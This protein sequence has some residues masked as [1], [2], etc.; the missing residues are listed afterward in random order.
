[1][2]VDRRRHIEGLHVDQMMPVDVETFFATLL[3]RLPRGA[4]DE[5]RPTLTAMRE[6]LRDT[7]VDLGATTA[8]TLDPADVDAT[9]GVI[10]ERLGQLKRREWRGKRDGERLIDRLRATVGELSADI[11]ELTGG[12]T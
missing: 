4:P 1:M 9:V 7:A 3:P 5:L 12:R 10:I 11:H 6:R 2:A 8:A